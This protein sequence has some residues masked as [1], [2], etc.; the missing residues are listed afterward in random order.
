MWAAM[1][2]VPRL[3]GFAGVRHL[4][5]QHQ[6]FTA[7]GSANPEVKAEAPKLWFAQ[8][9]LPKRINGP[10]NTKVKEEGLPGM[11]KWEKVDL[12]SLEKSGRHGSF[13]AGGKPP[14]KP[15]PNYAL[16]VPQLEQV[17]DSVGFGDGKNWVL[18]TTMANK[19]YWC[20]TPDRP[21]RED[22]PDLPGPFPET[23]HPGFKLAFN[24]RQIHVTI[25][26]WGPIDNIA[27]D[28]KIL[29]D[30]EFAKSSTKEVLPQEVPYA[31]EQT[32]MLPIC[33][34]K[35]NKPV[36]IEMNVT[37]FD[38]RAK[39]PK[40]Q[41]R[42]FDEVA[43]FD[44]VLVPPGSHPKFKAYQADMSVLLLP[45]PAVDADAARSA[46]AEQRTQRSRKRD[47]EAAMF[48]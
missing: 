23:R 44:A 18:N 19:E 21:D 9:D 27:D 3:P 43:A 41:D 10:T 7:F 46:A 15:G 32:K 13:S 26:D 24:A 2:G 36:R 30:A 35:G 28:P 22:K 47:L 37:G 11:K 42:S 25:T 5:D 40:G 4:Q 33:P 1:M 14:K 34:G 38:H 39:P 20:N 6:F 31:G 8:P 12:A 16:M 29:Y 48:L 17:G 45:P